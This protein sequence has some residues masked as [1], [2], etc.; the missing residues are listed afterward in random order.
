MVSR[1]I[2]EMKFAAKKKISQLRNKITTINHILKFS[3]NC[4][5]RRSHKRQSNS[6]TTIH[7]KT[8]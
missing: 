1:M 2:N 7:N 6:V 3:L 5:Y 8:D 4:H